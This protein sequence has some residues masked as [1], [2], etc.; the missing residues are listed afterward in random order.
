MTQSLLFP[1]GNVYSQNAVAK[2]LEN[3]SILKARLKVV[4]NFLFFFRFRVTRRRPP[5]M[6]SSS[7]NC[8]HR[9]MSSSANYRPFLSSF[10][11]ISPSGGF[12]QVSELTVYTK[13][14]GLRRWASG[15][16]Q[17]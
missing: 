15:H 7:K 17:G 16:L 1:M 5:R 6:M 9:M 8:L 3:S 11:H 12:C 14:G 13:N 2:Y 10:R 4:F